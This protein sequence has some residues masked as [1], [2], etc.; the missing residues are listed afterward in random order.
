LNEDL[1]E[2]LTNKIHELCKTDAIVD[3]GK[4][5]NGPWFEDPRKYKWQLSRT[6]K[7]ESDG[8]SLI[9]F[10]HFKHLMNGP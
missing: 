8:G 4:E 7:G 1:I 9:D 3:E 10:K 2:E 5:S 6:Y